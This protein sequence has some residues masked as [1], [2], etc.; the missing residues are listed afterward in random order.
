M[1]LIDTETLESTGAEE[2]KKRSYMAIRTGGPA[3][4]AC[5]RSEKSGQ[6]IWRT[7]QGAE[8]QPDTSFC[9]ADYFRLHHGP[10]TSN[11]TLFFSVVI[12][13]RRAL[14]RHRRAN[15]SVRRIIPGKFF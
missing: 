5:W 10:D 3:F 12:H 9:Q 11:G 15:C 8:R 14:F 7:A 4:A 2:R 6:K 1:T 13:R